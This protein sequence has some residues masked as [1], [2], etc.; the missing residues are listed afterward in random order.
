MSSKPTS[1]EKFLNASQITGKERVRISQRQT[2]GQ[3]LWENF[4]T[5]F[6]GFLKWLGSQLFTRNSIV[7][8]GS[9]GAPFELMN[10][11]STVPPNYDYGTDA[12]GVR[13]WHARTGGGGTLI[14]T[15]TNISNALSNGINTT[16]YDKIYITDR[17][18]LLPIDTSTNP[19]H[20]PLL[21]GWLNALN[22]DFQGAGDYS[23]VA[24]YVLYNGASA[25]AGVWHTGLELVTIT[26]DTL[27]G[28]NFVAGETITE[29]ANGAVGTC[30]SDDGSTITIFRTTPAN[31]YVPGNTIDNG[32]GVSANELTVTY[33][34]PAILVNGNVVFWNGSHYV[35]I[36][37]TAF[38]GTD[39]VTNNT[40]YQLLTPSVT[41][42]YINEVDDIQYKFA[43]D[44]LVYRADKRQNK[45]SD[46]NNAGVIAVFQWGNDNV[47][48][49]FVESGSTLSCLNQRGFIAD[50]NLIGSSTLY[51]TNLNEGVF[52]NQ[53]IIDAGGTIDITN[54]NNLSSN[55]FL[56]GGINA[57]IDYSF[58]GQTI[59]SSNSND[60]NTSTLKVNLDLDDAAI[61]AANVLTIPQK[62][63]IAGAFVLQ[64]ANPTYTINSIVKPSAPATLTR[65]FR[66]IPD[67]GITLTINSGLAANNPRLKGAIAFV[68]VGANF[69]FI[70]FLITG[71]GVDSYETNRA[72][73]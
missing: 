32:T 12:F 10:D 14:D 63:T 45:V 43:D 18:I 61:F 19:T 71:A 47:S 57:T 59:G 2:T 4:Q 13:Q 62:Y 5:D 60:N 27:I 3:K 52:Y 44:I 8:I 34:A 25:N 67:T 66:L 41:N 72:N 24:G 58:S 65:N 51:F 31:F 42:G 36:D 28:G 40:A 15:Y 17:S 20:T 11:L 29:A 54:G 33:P 48:G 1:S 50:N 39:P 23:G 73:Y 22:P 64:G 69:D 49:N 6:T 26:Y 16:L 56:G 9:Q 55:I 53:T 7:G 21:N 37:E 68:G 46:G 38:N 35:V 70:D 30:I